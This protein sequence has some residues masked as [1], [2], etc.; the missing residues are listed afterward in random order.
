MKCSKGAVRGDAERGSNESTLIRSNRVCIRESFI[1]DRSISRMIDDRL[2]KAWLT[3]GSLRLL[4]DSAQGLAA[5][6]G[7]Q[8]RLEVLEDRTSL[9]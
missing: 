7:N 2:T 8:H 3:C 9:S 4:L 6:N 1:S 5:P